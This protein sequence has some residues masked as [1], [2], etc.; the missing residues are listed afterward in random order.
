MVLVKDFYDAYAEAYADP[1]EHETA[2]AIFCMGFFGDFSC[3]VGMGPGKCDLLQKELPKL[4]ATK[5][6]SDLSDYY[7]GSVESA[8]DNIKQT[9][10]L[11]AAE[12]SPEAALAALVVFICKDVKQENPAYA[13]YARERINNLLKEA[14]PFEELVRKF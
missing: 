9:M 4:L 7:S 6:K 5:F 2:L 8:E 10:K 14:I 11:Y 13:K 12:K 1:A 3:R